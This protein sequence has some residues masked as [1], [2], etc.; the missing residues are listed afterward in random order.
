M[1]LIPP[2]FLTACRGKQDSARVSICKIQDI[3]TNDFD[4]AVDNPAET[5]KA[6]VLCLP[7]HKDPQFDHS[8]R[9]RIE[10]R[11]LFQY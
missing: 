9:G 2:L 4:V 11:A 5:T 10:S 6:A 1:S 7:E 8:G 3:E